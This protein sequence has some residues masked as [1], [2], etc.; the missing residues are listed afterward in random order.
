MHMKSSSSMRG[1]WIAVRIAV[2]TGA[3]SHPAGFR[4]ARTLE[5]G[6]SEHSV[7]V[8]AAGL[9]GHWLIESAVSESS[10]RSWFPQVTPTYALRYG[11]SDSVDV[12]GQI[13]LS[14]VRGELTYQLLESR[15]VD[16]ALGADLGFGWTIMGSR[17]RSTCLPSGDRVI[18][19]L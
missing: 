19:A 2:A 13:G 8:Q 14:F 12:G 4:P 6:R 16:V 10:W 17:E 15:W 3:C 9:Y 18:A 5:A 11:L 7:G 1:W